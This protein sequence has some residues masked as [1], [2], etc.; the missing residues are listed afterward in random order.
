M[1][2]IKFDPLARKT[3]PLST[4]VDEFFTRGIG[5]FLGSDFATN[6]PAVNIVE[7]EQGFHLELAAP[8][9]TKEHFKISVEMNRL[10]ISAGHTQEQNVEEAN[11]TR[12]EFN[13]S[14][15]SR[16]FFLPVS[17]D[18]DRITASYENGV[19][20]LMVPKKQEVINEQKTRMITIK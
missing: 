18:K 13:Y 17:I 12:R 1:N 2:L 3:S 6:V 7:N 19:L 16:S 10:T 14:T 9:L 15:F 4:F 8:G 5:D 20:R 11:F